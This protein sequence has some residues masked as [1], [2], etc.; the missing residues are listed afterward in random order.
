[1]TESG[2]QW[3]FLPVSRFDLI[4]EMSSHRRKPHFLRH[5]RPHC[6]ET[7]AD[8][9][10][11][12][13]VDYLRATLDN[14]IEEVAS[15]RAEA[16]A[17][18][19]S[20]RTLAAVDPAAPTSESLAKT[21]NERLL[22][23]SVARCEELITHVETKIA[24]NALRAKNDPA[25]ARLGLPPVAAPLTVPSASIVVAEQG[26]CSYFTRTMTNTDAEVGGEA[27]ADL[28]VLEGWSVLWVLRYC[29]LTSLWCFRSRDCVSVPSSRPKMLRSSTIIRG[30]SNPSAH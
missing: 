25:R 4:H 22:R 26:D 1:M 5:A 23:E 20:A 18:R 15:A 8:E 21:E 17:V 19:S 9:Q 11:R 24:M 30:R 16:V 10:G 7:P 13:D 14:A 12:E 28:G 6:S 27:F 3:K 29:P 2:S